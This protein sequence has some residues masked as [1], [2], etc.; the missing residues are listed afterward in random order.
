MK[1]L[2][3]S[4]LINFS[5]KSTLLDMSIAIPACLWGPFAWKSFFH[6]WCKASGYFFQWDESLVSNIWL[7][8]VCKP[9]LLF[10]VFLL[11]HCRHLHSMLILRGACCFQPFLFPC[12]FVLPIPCL[13]VC[14]LKRFYFFL[15]S[16]CLTLVSSSIC[17]GPVSILWSAGMV[18]ANSFSF[19]FCGRF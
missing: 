19:T 16:S 4:L 17:K 7:R 13:L 18:V 14:L 10:Y 11:R 2:S 5:L 1:G 12:C 8:L 9:I 6:L 15:E 3:L